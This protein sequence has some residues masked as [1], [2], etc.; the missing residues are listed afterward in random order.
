M[1]PLGEGWV[2]GVLLHV[3]LCCVHQL[4]SKADQERANMHARCSAT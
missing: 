3:C 4:T 1:G 2:G